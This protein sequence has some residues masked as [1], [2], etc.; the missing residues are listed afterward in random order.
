MK[1]MIVGMSTA[2]IA[3]ML[4]LQNLG[5]KWIENAAQ[6]RSFI[7]NTFIFLQLFN[8]INCRV[9]DRSLNVFRHIFG[10]PFF[11]VIW[12]GTAI[13]QVGIIFLGGEAFSTVPLTWQQ[14]LVSIAI[15][16]ASLPI[17]FLIRLIPD[18]FRQ[19][20]VTTLHPT[21]GQLMWQSA[22]GDVQR[23]LAFFT[24]IRRARRRQSLRLSDQSGVAQVG[25]P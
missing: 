15:G 5:S 25:E 2:H 13:V 7:F 20:T 19:S 23:S 24:A 10:N 4:L 18:W 11:I 6:H 16:T 12:L 9:L 3:I 14:W 22:I 17:G 21:P 8:E 1:R